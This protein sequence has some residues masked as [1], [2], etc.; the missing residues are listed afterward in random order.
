MKC[1]NKKCRNYKESEENNCG[2]WTDCLNNVCDIYISYE[3]HLVDTL[4]AE[5]E[6]VKKRNKVLEKALDVACDRLDDVSSCHEQNWK[7]IT[8]NSDWKTC[9]ANKLFHGCKACIKEDII[10]NAE[11]I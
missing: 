3:D 2:S 4:K 1:F 7:I 5:L 6:S 9:N 10:T 8:V 11:G